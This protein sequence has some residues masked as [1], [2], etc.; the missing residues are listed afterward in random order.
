MFLL[1]ILLVGFAGLHLLPAIPRL[2]NLA[3]R[4]FGKAYG[5]AYGIGSLMLLIGAIAAF[6][7]A[8]V[9]DVYDVPNWGKHSNFILTLFAFIFVGI[10]M[11]RGSWRNLVKYPMAVAVLLWAAG[12]VLAN[13]DSRSLMFFGSFAVIALVQVFVHSRLEERAGHNMLSILFGIAAYG[14][15]AQL[16]GALIGV[17]VFNIQ[18]L[19]P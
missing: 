18:G 3:K 17:P 6:R 7:A 16:H 19:S 10:F 5:P 15:F 11:F 2:R 14:V 9:A 8:P 4:N 13:G 1:A 12:H